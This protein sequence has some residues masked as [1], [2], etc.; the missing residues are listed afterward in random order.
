MI[1]ALARSLLAVIFIKGGADAFL[2]PGGRPARV[3]RFGVPQPER[4]VVL[5]GATMVVAGSALAL[6]WFPRLAA[7]VLL[8]SLVP[9]TIV[10][11]PFWQ[12]RDPQTHQAQQTQFFKN[13]GLMGGLLLVLLEESGAKAAQT[14][15]Q[16]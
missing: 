13:L 6:G 15:A 9:T 1:R 8:A 11:H 4:A 16:G 10:G 3:A 14:G 12:E 7:A 5:N 2:N